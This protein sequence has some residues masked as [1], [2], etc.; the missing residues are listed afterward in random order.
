MA[1]WVRLG[2]KNPTQLSVLDIN[3]CSSLLIKALEKNVL[4]ATRASSNYTFG[5]IGQILDNFHQYY[6]IE[7]IVY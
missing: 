5:Q 3:L 7:T 1:F 6:Y 2:I 4:V